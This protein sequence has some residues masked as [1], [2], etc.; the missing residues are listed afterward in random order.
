MHLRLQ[1]L[2]D[3]YD[4]NSETEY[5]D[6]DRIADAL[7]NAGN[8]AK[9]ANYQDTKINELS[10]TG[11]ME[12]GEMMSRKIK[13][14]TVDDDKNDFPKS[15]I[16]YEINTSKV[17]LEPQRIRVFSVRYITEEPTFLNN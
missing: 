10:L 4:S 2:A 9:P 5:V 12:I 17:T 7:W 16:D 8:M 13:W 1:N 14:P 6:L 3:L 15:A 11:N